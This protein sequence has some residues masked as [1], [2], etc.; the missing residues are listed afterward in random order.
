MSSKKFFQPLLERKTPFKRRGQT[1]L[2]YALLM[3]LLFLAVGVSMDLGWYY[4]NVSR[5]QNAADAAALAGANALVNVED[6][7]FDNYYVVSLTNNNL[8]KDFEDYE[9]IFDNKTNSIYT[10]GTL[11]NYKTKEEIHDT[12]MHGR[13]NVE[14]YTKKNLAD[15]YSEEDIPSVEEWK[16]VSATDGWSISK[17]DAD[18]KVTGNIRLMYKII[19]AKNDNFGPLYYVVSLKEQIRHFFLP[20]WF[21]DMNAPVTAVA[22]LY[23]RNKDLLAEMQN[24]EREKV[25]DNWEYQN[26]YKGTQGA[27]SGKWNHYMSEKVG[28]KTAIA[29]KDNNPYRTESVSVKTTAEKS[30]GQKTAANT[31]GAINA[32]DGTF[33]RKEEVDSINIDFQAEIRVKSQMF[34]SDW[35]LGMPIPNFNRYAQTNSDNWGL[36]NGDDKR[37]LFN[38][39]FNEAFPNRSSEVDPLWVRI[40]SEPIITQK[41]YDYTKGKDATVDVYNS[42]RQITLNF[43]ADNSDIATY[44]PYVI[45]YTGAENIDQENGKQVRH[46]QPVVVNLNANTNA[47]LYMPESPV[48]LN[49]ND[50]TLRGFIIARCFLKSVEGDELKSHRDIALYDGFEKKTLFGNFSEGTDGSGQTIYYHDYNLLDKETEI[51][52]NSKY[53]DSTITL[54]E[55]GNVLI[56][57]MIQ[58]PKYPVLN[59][60]KDLYTGLTNLA[61]YFDATREYI[62]TNYTKEKYA[63]LMG[64][65]VSEVAM[66]TFPD[67]KDNK[68]NKYG[69]FTGVEFPV[70]ND[71]NIL[72]DTD[73]DSNVA[74]KD[75]VYVKVMLGDTPKYINKS[76]LPYFR[77]KYNEHYPY[78]C[79]YDLKTGLGSGLESEFVCV[80]PTDDSIAPPN[81]KTDISA[82]VF[83]NPDNDWNDTWVIDRTLLTET[84]NKKYK[85]DKLQFAEKDNVKYFNLK[86][87]IAALPKEPQVIAKYHKVITAQGDK[88]I[89]DDDD[90]KIQY[91][92]KVQNN[93]HNLANYIIVDKKGNILTKAITPP[94]VLTTNTYSGNIALKE[95]AEA[96]GSN[97]TLFKYFNEYTRVPNGT[98]G[99]DNKDDIPKEIP[100]DY[101]Q[102]VNNKYVGTHPAHLHMDYRIPALER[103]YYKSLDSTFKLSGDSC[104]SYFQI[105]SLS[106]TNYKYL[107]VDPFN[108]T[109][110]NVE[111]DDWKVDDMFFLKKRAA[112]M[113]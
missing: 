9:N 87:D 85:A 18:K 11:K 26:R 22:L 5:L 1:M 42:V 74:A 7:A 50:N 82:V 90:D 3:P 33:F 79:I 54:D 10:L 113:D 84:Y 88:Y 45:F 13:N 25:I 104:Y 91:Y 64:L 72:L 57:E 60:N 59:F 38:A 80:K 106:R 89:K 70:P 8:P 81:D 58:A 15:A 103:I 108:Q 76:Y 51:D 77:V 102:I 107:N 30:G 36:G 17:E 16:V 4:L 46:S 27:Y 53:K 65:N 34:T 105:P 98:P 12:M 93:S 47:I 83:L 111:S 41:K 20:G 52:N 75:D 2:L 73:P 63:Q 94:E 44:R 21:D 101:G 6:G 110:N 67:E 69:N 99:A 40:E 71:E 86:T 19:D 109:K 55:K 48:V 24:L 112:W 68:Y 56:K 32:S 61:D 39:E 43:N 35:D 92:T 29:Y 96:A 100:L 28:S 97:S 62:R 14:K 78:V 95:R 37:I 66:L 23:P 31:V 49:G